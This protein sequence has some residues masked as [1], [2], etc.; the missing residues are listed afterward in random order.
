MNMSLSPKQKNYLLTLARK[1]ITDYFSE[2]GKVKIDAKEIDGDLLKP[3]ATFVTLTK[4]DELRGCIGNLIAK[5]P[6]YQDIINNSLLA[7]FSDNRFPQVKKE[8]LTEIKIEISILTRPKPYRYD[9]IDSLLKSIEPKNHGVII[10]NGFFQATYLP[11]VWDDLP[12]KIEFLESL[13]QKAGLPKNAWK[14]PETEIFYYS[15]EK[16]R[17][18]DK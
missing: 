6:L 1:T 2:G 9:N 3:A 18:P 13:C 15:A 16:F 4:S 11:Q 14:D 17:E 10:Q 7:A 5:K 8:E 12:D